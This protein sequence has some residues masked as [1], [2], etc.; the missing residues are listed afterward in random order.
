MLPC[1]VVITLVHL[2]LIQMSNIC[3]SKKKK[4]SGCSNKSK[5]ILRNLKTPFSFFI[6][7][8]LPSLSQQYIRISELTFLQLTNETITLGIY[9]S[10][11]INQDVCLFFSSF[12]GQIFR[13][14]L[15]SGTVGTTSYKIQMPYNGKLLIQATCNQQ[16]YPA[17][18]FIRLNENMQTCILV[19]L[20]L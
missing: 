19:D 6:L 20:I 2:L 1:N 15:F 11:T 7:V 5:L 9:R 4:I 14:Y 8:S 13:F 3:Q 17:N 18:R 16:V 10:S 12:P